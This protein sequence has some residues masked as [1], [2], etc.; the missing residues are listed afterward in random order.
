MET[1]NNLISFV[2]ENKA[3]LLKKHFKALSVGV[4]YKKSHSFNEKKVA[5]FLAIDSPIHFANFLRVPLKNLTELINQPNYSSYTIPK[6]K[7]GKRNIEAP[8]LELKIIQRQINYYL[9]HYYL[10]LKPKNVH[11]FVIKD[12][13]DNSA[14]NIIENARLHTNSKY[15]LTIS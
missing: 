9:Q 5:P 7:G 13:T 6:K 4:I 10:T 15:V 1:K 12:V 3:K 8:G 2:K 11:G 14:F